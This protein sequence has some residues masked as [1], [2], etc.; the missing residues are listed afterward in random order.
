M[1]MTELLED[2][3]KVQLPGDYLQ[4]AGRFHYRF[5]RIHPF[6]DGNGRMAR[7]LST[8]LIAKHLPTVLS[9]STP[10]NEVLREHRE[11]YVGVLRYCDYIHADLTGEDVPEAKKLEWCEAPFVLFYGRVTLRAFDAQAKKLE[12]ELVQAGVT[13]EPSEEIPTEQ[14]D[15]RLETIKS[16]YSWDQAKKESLLEPERPAVEGGKE[17]TGGPP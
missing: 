5:V 1:V 9:L 12:T 13:S 4:Q 10:V 11:E 8:F 3:G 15:L 6:C 2:A 7:A 17:P 16:L 14:L